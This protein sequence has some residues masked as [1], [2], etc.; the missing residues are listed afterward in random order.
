MGK[1]HPISQ[2][3][4]QA[5]FVVGMG[6]AFPAADPADHPGAGSEEGYETAKFDRAGGALPIR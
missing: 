2:K 1:A 4:A 5:G 3:C 6:Y